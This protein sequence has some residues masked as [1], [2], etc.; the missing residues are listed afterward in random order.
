[1][2]AGRY[3]LGRALFASRWWVRYVV[4]CSAMVAAAGLFYVVAHN[5]MLIAQAWH[6]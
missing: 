2:I 3:R 1:V 6:L 4:T 5:T